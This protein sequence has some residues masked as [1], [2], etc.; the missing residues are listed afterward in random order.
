VVTASADG[1]FDGRA[2]ALVEVAEQ[3]LVARL[4]GPRQ[5]RL[6]GEAAFTVEVNNLGRVTAAGVRVRQVLPRGL[7]IVSAGGGTFDPGSQAITWALPDLPGGQKRTVQFKVRAKEVGNW[8]LLPAVLADGV[9]SSTVPHAVHVEAAP[10]LALEATAEGPLESGSETSCEVRI[11]NHGKKAN[12]VRLTVRLPDNLAVLRSD[13]PT[14]AQAQGQLILF[15]PLPHLG[16]RGVAVYR[17]RLRGLR[18]GPGLLRVEVQAGG[19]ERPLQREL[20][21]QVRGSP[22]ASRER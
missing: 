20:T 6:G 11:A 19:L 1:R 4:D 21:T 16:G 2:D 12:A 15:D 7:E 5:A 18:P 9:G 3:S 10:T 13:G 8:A 22:L 14:R 17:L